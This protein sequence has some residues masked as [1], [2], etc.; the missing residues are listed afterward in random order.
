MAYNNNSKKNPSLFERESARDSQPDLWS[1]SSSNPRVLLD[2]NN[3]ST[4]NLAM[5]SEDEKIIIEVK[6][7]N[8]FLKF[9]SCLLSGVQ[10][11]FNE[12]ATRLERD[13][14]SFKLSYLDEGNDEISLSCDADLLLCAKTQISMGKTCIHLLAHVIS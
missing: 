2:I 7:E 6:F 3:A 11:V 14:S 8:E 1:S 4:Q 10:N 13:G 9:E 12:I 5:K